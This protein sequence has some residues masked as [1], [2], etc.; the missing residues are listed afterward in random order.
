MACVAL[1]NV[2]QAISV[3]FTGF[4]FSSSLSIDSCEVVVRHFSPAAQQVKK[5]GVQLGF[6]AAQTSAVAR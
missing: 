1:V 5:L 3:L 6:S 4:R 2:Q